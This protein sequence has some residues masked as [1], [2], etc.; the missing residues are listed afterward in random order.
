MANRG[1]GETFSSLV[2]NID[3]A[4][5]TNLNI[6]YNDHNFFY[7]L[8]L[9]S[10]KSSKS[11]ALSIIYHRIGNQLSSNEAFPHQMQFSF[12]KDF[13]FQSDS[14]DVTNADGSIDEYI[15]SD[16]SQ[17]KYYCSKN[18]TYITADSATSTRVLIESDGSK[19]FYNYG[20]NYPGNFY[21][22][23]SSQMS[24]AVEIVNHKIMSI[25]AKDP[26]DLNDYYMIFHYL[27]DSGYLSTITIAK[28]ELNIIQNYVE[29]ITFVYETSGSCDIDQIYWS[30]GV[31]HSS[32]EYYRHISLSFNNESD[33]LFLIQDLIS[34]LRAEYCF[35]TRCDWFRITHC[36]DPL[37][38]EKKNYLTYSADQ[39]KVDYFDGTSSTT[40]YNSSSLPMFSVDSQGLASTYRFDDNRHIVYQSKPICLDKSA[41]LPSIL[42]NNLFSNGTSGWLITGLGSSASFQFPYS[43]IT[44]STG[45]NFNKISQTVSVK[46]LPGEAYTFSA[47][48][49]GLSTV[50]FN[51][52]LKISI[53]LKNSGGIVVASN[54]VLSSFYS[55]KHSCE[56]LSVSALSFTAFSSIEVSIEDSNS[57]NDW[58]INQA[59]LLKSFPKISAEYDEKGDL[60]SAY[61]KANETKVLYDKKGR[62]LVIGSASGANINTRFLTS[63]PFVFETSY[64][65][66]SNCTYTTYFEDYLPSS[67]SNS[68]SQ[69]YYS[70]NPY[71]QKIS[72]NDRITQI[73]YIFNE[74][75]DVTSINQLNYGNQNLLISREF[76]FLSN[77]SDLIESIKFSDSVTEDE[78]SFSY[79]NRLFSSL[80]NNEIIE[81]IPAYDSVEDL[82]NLSLKNNNVSNP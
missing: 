63:C 12:F 33:N 39:T 74:Y 60:L 59:W 62:A 31:P 37:I 8:P 50:H 34:H 54:S 21:S 22:N 4:G 71:R 77:R 41:N 6:S 29:T 56:L 69:V 13:N 79:S 27:S 76:T 26:L 19:Y 16:D 40:Y 14:I 11:F 66:F 44:G 48:V 2:H 42:V 70:Y 57:S 17:N 55:A 73:D 51:N 72:E 65:D 52:P 45:I 67:M 49:A 24:Y 78:Y 20:E 61:S 9:I 43:S 64:S 10:T 15:K 47:F 80:K 23:N 1:I 3:D 46:G 75:D 58:I 68:W 18:N 35:S 30:K 25:S 81:Y 5:T 53:T 32:N 38:E 36:N 28:R 82:T 7:I